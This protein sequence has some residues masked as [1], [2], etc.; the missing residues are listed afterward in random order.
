MKQPPIDNAYV[1]DGC[2][3]FTPEEVARDQRTQL[4]TAINHERDP[5]CIGC[6]T[7]Q[8]NGAI[9]EQWLK[10][11]CN[12]CG[13][14][15][16][17]NPGTLSGWR[18]KANIATGANDPQ[19]CDWPTCDCDPYA[20]KVIDAL[21]DGGWSIVPDEPTQEMVDAA[22]ALKLG[23][24]RADDIAPDGMENAIRQDYKAMVERSRKP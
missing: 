20:A 17:F 19:D 23:R 10:L 12:A 22:V 13:D 5:R 6:W 16:H 1:A 7:V 14:V 11:V 24:I 2:T 3:Q 8:L 18:C 9:S 21:C 4:H 15:R